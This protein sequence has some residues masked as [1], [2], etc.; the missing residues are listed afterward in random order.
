MN[1][2]FLFKSCFYDWKIY[3]KY[4]YWCDVRCNI[5]V[6]IIWKTTSF[7]LAP[8]THLK[9]DIFC[10]CI[11]GAASCKISS[12]SGVW[13]WIVILRWCR[14]RGG[15]LHHDIMAGVNREVKCNVHRFQLITLNKIYSASTRYWW[16]FSLQHTALV[17]LSLLNNN[18]WMVC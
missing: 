6:C 8:L 9:Q 4:Y 5:N 11:L 15:V 18:Q 13:L 16:S 3:S 14:R 12:G 7:S 17:H 2:H 1:R 10:I